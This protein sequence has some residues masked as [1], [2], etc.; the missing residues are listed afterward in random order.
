MWSLF[1]PHGLCYTPKQDASFDEVDAMPYSGFLCLISTFS[2]NFSLQLSPSTK[3]HTLW[4]QAR[5]LLLPVTQ[6][7]KMSASKL[8]HHFSSHPAAFGF[9][10]SLPPDDITETC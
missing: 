5:E 2:N 6:A 1:Y 8:I 7:G 3:S 10:V 9:W 4:C